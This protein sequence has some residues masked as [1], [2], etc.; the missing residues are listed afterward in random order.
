MTEP[1]PVPMISITSLNEML[2]TELKAVKMLALDDTR[3]TAIIMY[4]ESFQRRINRT[5]FDMLVKKAEED[6]G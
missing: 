5:A 3:K 1:N 4:I 6:N 2:D